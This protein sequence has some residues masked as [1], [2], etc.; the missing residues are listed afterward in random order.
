MQTI[1]YVLQFSVAKNLGEV[2]MESPKW[3]AK[4]QLCRWVNIG[5]TVQDRDTVTI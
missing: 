3:G 4:Y 5:E 1:T 2:S